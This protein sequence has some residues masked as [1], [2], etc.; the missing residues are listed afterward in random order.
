M[1]IAG[2]FIRALDNPIV[3]KDGI[4]RMRSWRAPLAITL[5]LGLLGAFGFGIFSIEV[6]SS[7]Y[8]RPVSAEIGA[9]VFGALAWF[10]LVL[11]C[12]FAPA[13]ASA[14][15]SGER[16][17]QTFDVLL[18]SGVSAFGIGPSTETFETP[19]AAAWLR[20]A[21]PSGPSPATTIRTVGALAARMAAASSTVPNACPAPKFPR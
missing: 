2:R 11:I 12:L 19:L 13:L 4:S 8:S 20:N 7:S 6:L 21:F 3:A 16:E 5:Y 14:A 10:Q 1:S 15:I 17:R 9:A 18:V